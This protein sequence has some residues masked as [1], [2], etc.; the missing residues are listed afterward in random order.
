MSILLG[1]AAR[2]PCIAQSR[3]RW[4]LATNTTAQHCHCV[5]SRSASNT[6]RG[7]KGSEHRE[8][9]GMVLSS[10]VSRGDQLPA[11]GYSVFPQCLQVPHTLLI[12]SPSGH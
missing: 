6:Y 12:R 10:L 7:G 11:V 2:T 1:N 5:T 3:V 9:A 8:R 4:R